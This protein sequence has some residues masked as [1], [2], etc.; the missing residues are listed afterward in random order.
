VLLL[1]LKEYTRRMYKGFC[2]LTGKHSDS[3]LN[4]VESRR[5][6]EEE[7]GRSNN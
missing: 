2:I 5:K 7:T 3:S 4:M 6:K 1:I